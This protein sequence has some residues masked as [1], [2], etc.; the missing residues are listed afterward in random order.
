[1]EE[2]R[3]ETHSGPRNI[4]IAVEDSE[5]SLEAVRY[6]GRILPA[7]ELG[8]T[9]FHVLNP[10]P[11]CFYDLELAPSFGSQ[12]AGY[13]TWQAEQK[14]MIQDFMDRARDL[15][16]D[17][18]RPR[19]AISVL[20]QERETGVARDIAKKAREGFDTL[21]VGRRGMSE[22]RDLILGSIAHKLV[23]YLNQT[24]VW[25]V[26]G[27]PDPARILVAMDSSD[28]AGRALDYVWETFGRSHPEILLLHVARGLDCLR[29]DGE[30]TVLGAHWIERAREEIEKAERAM[31]IVFEESIDRLE[32]RGADVIR[33]KTKIV[34]GV[35]SRAAAILGE[36]R[37][38]DCGTIVV[39]R[40]GLSR[41]EEFFMGRVSNKVLQMAREMAVWL[42]H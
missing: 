24:T 29:P 8:I 41:V 37:E 31:A 32:Q 40:R 34:P 9:L 6:V 42:V 16:F 33:I 1:M 26:G 13:H 39:G 36:A 25:V 19:K 3:L 30:G 14:R 4:L 2:I 20:I 18:G 17:L 15:L 12:V 22:V 35:Y 23:T 28:G 21:V 27:Q 5:H 11:E 10:V 7:E 38:E